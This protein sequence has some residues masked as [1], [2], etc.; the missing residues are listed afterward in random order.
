MT[1]LPTGSNIAMIRLLL[2]FRMMNRLFLSQ[3]LISLQITEKLLF[4]KPPVQY[5]L[6]ANSIPTNLEL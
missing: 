6:R 3:M 2:I 1:L 5:V 4:S